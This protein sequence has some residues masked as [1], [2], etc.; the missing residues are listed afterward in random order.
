M[1]LPFLTHGVIRTGPASRTALAVEPAR[2]IDPGSSIYCDVQYEGCMAR[3]DS[4]YPFRNDDRWSYC[5]DDCH[6][7]RES[8]ESIFAP[9]FP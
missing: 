4:S 5:W 8:C 3:C 7:D 9:R 2:E 1:N 6:A